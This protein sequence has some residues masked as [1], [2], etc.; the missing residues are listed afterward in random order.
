M[1]RAAD[2]APLAGVY[3]HV[4]FCSA[5]CSYC[6]FN[7]GLLD[8]DLKRRYVAALVREIERSGDGTDVDTI[9]VGGGT[10]SLLQAGELGA[11]IAAC[12]RAFAVTCPAEITLEVNPET[13][14]PDALAGWREV[15]VNRLSIGVQ[16][17]R[18]D[19]LKRLGRIHDAARARRAVG[20]ARDAGFGNISL[21]LMMWLPGQRVEHWLESVE[22]L[23]EAAPDHASLYLLELYPN[24]PLR[25]E[26]ARGGWSLAPDDDA[27]DMYLGALD[28]LDRAG[29]EQYE[30]SN[31]ARP[32]R[33]SRH[34]LKYWTDG[35][36][37]AFGCGAHGTRGGTRWRNLSATDE[38]VARIE[39]GATVVAE[40]RRLSDHDRFVEAMITGL[41]LG[42]GVD[43]EE[44]TSRH[45][46]DVMT[47]YGDRLGPPL[48][49]GLLLLEGR[50]LRL[51]RQGML[52]ANEI[53]GVFV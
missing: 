10:P 11:V 34:N 28:R 52:V 39:T 4:P 16:S 8:D 44:V 29:F 22:A 14:T 32:G 13:A 47:A 25:D 41:R 36:W 7:R 37:L 3:V 18:D 45:G 30:I 15:G 35:E 26:M 27:A 1:T 53:L 40:S 20:D 5:I 17:F 21:D 43:L 46:V 31:V 49:A 12:R 51:S 23:V 19:E 48:E 38:Y 42:R 24:A 33:Q 2:R 9:Y 6:N 50:R